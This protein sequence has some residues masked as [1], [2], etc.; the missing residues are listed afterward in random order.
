MY[1]MGSAHTSRFLNPALV[2][3]EWAMCEFWRPARSGLLAHL[4]HRIH[5]PKFLLTSETLSRLL[6]TP[7]H[8]FAGG[9]ISDARISGIDDAGVKNTKHLASARWANLSLHERQSHEIEYGSN[10]AQVIME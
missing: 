10:N 9:N 7:V 5:A 6:L 1:D 2:A 4:N 8:V 3:E